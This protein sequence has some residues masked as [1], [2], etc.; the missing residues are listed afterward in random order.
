MVEKSSQDNER[1]HPIWSWTNRTDEEL[2][3]IL[4]D[5]DHEEFGQ[6]GARLLD[7]TKDLE[8]VADFV[9][10]EILGNHYERFRRNM[11]SDRRSIQYWDRIVKTIRDQLGIEVPGEEWSPTGGMASRN[12][13]RQIKNIREE[14]GMTQQDLAERLDVSR[15]AV[16]QIENGHRKLTIERLRRIADALNY[17]ANIVLKPNPGENE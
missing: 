16:S 4:S 2:R 6:T 13:G 10:K 1:T 14:K 7:S 9:D 3:V 17:Q 15:Q 5:P 12:I 8:Q 11:S